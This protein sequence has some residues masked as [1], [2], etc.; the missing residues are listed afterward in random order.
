VL[1]NMFSL[2]VGKLKQEKAP[3]ISN[4]FTLATEARRNKEQM[5]ISF[6]EEIQRWSANS[7][8]ICRKGCE[9]H[10]HTL[11]VNA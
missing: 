1:A 7:L 6:F 4:V 8:L 11:R 2:F 3:F 5:L 10:G 9:V